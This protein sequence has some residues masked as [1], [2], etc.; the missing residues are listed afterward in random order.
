MA[1]ADHLQHKTYSRFVQLHGEN[2]SFSAPS[3]YLL[4]RSVIF[5]KKFRRRSIFCKSGNANLIT[6]SYHNRNCTSNQ[7]LT[8]LH[9]FKGDPGASTHSFGLR[10]ALGLHT[11]DLGLRENDIRGSGGHGDDGEYD[12][13]SAWS[14]IR[15]E[16]DLAIDDDSCNCP[17]SSMPMQ[18]DG[19]DRSLNNDNARCG[20]GYGDDKDGDINTSENVND[21]DDFSLHTKGVM[22]EASATGVHEGTGTTNSF[23]SDVSAP[24]AGEASGADNDDISIA[25]GLMG[26][27]AAIRMQKARLQVLLAVKLLESTN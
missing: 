22:Q 2:Y 6:C 1:A 23:D 4:S 19:M 9:S 8:R 21:D 10:T 17:L 15:H 7:L 24:S 27:A 18:S 20:W 16:Q 11:A 26:P 5:S 14:K 25:L 3:L 13:A 12:A